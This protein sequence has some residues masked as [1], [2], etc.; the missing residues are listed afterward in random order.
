MGCGLL[1]EDSRREKEGCPRGMRWERRENP[2]TGEGERV[3]VGAAGGKVDGKW[4][5][6]KADLNQSKGRRWKRPSASGREWT[7]IIWGICTRS[8]WHNDGERQPWIKVFAAN[9][10]G[11]MLGTGWAERMDAESGLEGPA[12]KSLGDLSEGRSIAAIEQRNG[13][14]VGANRLRR[15][16]EAATCRSLNSDLVAVL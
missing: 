3:L 7:R 8:G 5:A 9:M 1:A 2:G 14:R 13:A 10:R 4:G 11:Q 12:G 6:W 15:G 16:L